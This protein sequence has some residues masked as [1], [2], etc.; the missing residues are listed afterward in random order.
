MGIRKESGAADAARFTTRRRCAPHLSAAMK[1]PLW[2]F[3]GNERML[4]V[5]LK[6]ALST[7]DAA[8]QIVGSPTPPHGSLPPDG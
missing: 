8:T 2:F 6:N 5:A 4:A 1:R 7:A 3:R